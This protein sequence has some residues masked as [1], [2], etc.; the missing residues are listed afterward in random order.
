MKFWAVLGC[1][2]TVVASPLARQL[3]D[4]LVVHPLEQRAST[5]LTLLGY[6]AVSEV[7]L[8]LQL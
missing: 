3:E 5:G 7:R 8:L 4:S 6:R 2:A 1:V